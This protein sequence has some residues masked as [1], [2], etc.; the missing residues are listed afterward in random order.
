MVEWFG[1]QGRKRWLAGLT[2]ALAIGLIAGGVSIA[3]GPKDEDGIDEK[4]V[5]TFVDITVDEAFVDEE[6]KAAGEE[7]ISPGDAFFFRDELWNRSETKKKGE[8]Q[9]MCA[10][11]FNDKGHCEATVYLRGGT[12]QLEGGVSFSEDSPGSF[13]VAVT[14][15][16]EK[17]KNVVGQATIIEG[18]GPKGKLKLELL[19]ASEHDDDNDR[20][21]R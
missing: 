20:Q 1:A 21:A 18:D 13:F 8:L 9:G 7:N 10:F 15:G 17:Y 12:V 3:G 19:P 2:L 16:T 6:P 11:L 4:K 14:G 5:L